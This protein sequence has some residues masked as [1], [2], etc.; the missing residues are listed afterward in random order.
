MVNNSTIEYEKVVW[1]MWP[2]VKIIFG[3]TSNENMI[4]LYA[5]RTHARLM[6][7]FF[8]ETLQVSSNL[9]NTSK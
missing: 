8:V 5:S 2:F 6:L 4:K 9:Q 1:F 3:L 7:A